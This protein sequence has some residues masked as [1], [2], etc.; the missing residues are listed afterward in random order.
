[1]FCMI[2]IR[3]CTLD[4]HSTRTPGHCARCGFNLEEYK[5]RIKDI[6]TNGLQ[7]AGYGIRRYVISRGEV[8][9]T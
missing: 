9:R 6:R 1:M 5:R 4:R 8:S 2:G 3:N 7:E